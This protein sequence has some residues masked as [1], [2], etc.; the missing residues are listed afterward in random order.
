[1][2]IVAPT[3]QKMRD[4]IEHAHDLRAQAL[5]AGLADFVARLRKAF[6]TMKP[7]SATHHA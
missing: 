7:N 1:M 2:L 3:D 6:A 4:A 5:T